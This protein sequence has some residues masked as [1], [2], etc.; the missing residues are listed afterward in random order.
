MTFEIGPIELGKEL[1]TRISTS[2]KNN[3]E[4]Y[5]DDNGLEMQKR[6]FNGTAGDLVSG[7]YYPMVARSYLQDSKKQ[8]QVIFPA[9]NKIPEKHR[10]EIFY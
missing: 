3:R 4:F 7:N 10:N 2:M 5:T 8:L 1:V 6:V 9:K